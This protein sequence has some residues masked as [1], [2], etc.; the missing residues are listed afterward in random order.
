MRVVVAEDHALLREGLTRILEANGFEVVGAVDN[1]STL[2][3]LLAEVEP[4]L[5]ILDVRMPPTFT[6][7]GI[8]AAAELR[9]RDRASRCWC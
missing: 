5:V 2:M 4:D 9:A 8:V 7:E 3:S 1:T 6:N